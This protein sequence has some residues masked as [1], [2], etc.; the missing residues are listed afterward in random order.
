M[1]KLLLLTL[2]IFAFN[3]FAYSQVKIGIVDAQRLVSESARGKEIQNKLEY[4]KKSKENELKA[5]ANALAN[6]QK[7]LQSPAFDQNTREKK[8]VEMQNMR[9]KIKRATDDAQNALQG[10]TQREL[11]NLQ[12]EVGPILKSYGK[13]NGFSIIFNATDAS[14]VYFDDAIDITAEIIQAYDA[15][16]QE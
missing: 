14:I 13:T 12:N 15:R 1:R 7:E 8:T 11:T 4:L 16:Y 2:V 10:E 6:L 5:M 9:V 3:G